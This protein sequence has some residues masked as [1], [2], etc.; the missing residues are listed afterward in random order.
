MQPE[1]KT[2]CT[3]N[4]APVIKVELL[5]K[6]PAII[7]AKEEIQQFIKIIKDDIRELK[8]VLLNLAKRKDHYIKLIDQG[9]YNPVAMEVSLQQMEIEVRK[10]NDK[11]DKLL[12]QK[13]HYADVIK[14]LDLKLE[15]AEKWD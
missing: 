3:S 7:E 14:I 4:D 2:P 8:D 10:F 1:L 6:T 13:S 12:A 15:E 5:F 11:I 9:K